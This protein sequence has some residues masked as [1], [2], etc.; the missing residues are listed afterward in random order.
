[1]AT[2][3]ATATAQMARR[4]GALQDEVTDLMNEWMN[5][6]CDEEIL[7]G[8]SRSSATAKIRALIRPIGV[9]FAEEWCY[10]DAM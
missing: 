8:S 9:E 2:A 7:R 4:V 5:A 6:L 1:M 10:G 3:T